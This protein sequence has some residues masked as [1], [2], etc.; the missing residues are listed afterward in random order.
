M[1]AL[2]QC[3]VPAGKLSGETNTAGTVTA[4]GGQMQAGGIAGPGAILLP[5]RQH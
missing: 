1:E 3:L 2:R 5:S 4:G